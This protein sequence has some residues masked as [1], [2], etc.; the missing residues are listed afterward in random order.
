MS[1]HQAMYTLCSLLWSG[2]WSVT[3]LRWLCAGLQISAPSGPEGRP[4]SGRS[5][6]S[7]AT[8]AWAPRPAAWRKTAADL[9]RQTAAESEPPGSCTGAP[10]WRPDYST[11]YS[12]ATSHAGSHRNAAPL[13]PEIELPPNRCRERQVKGF[14]I[15]IY[16]LISSKLL[17]LVSKGMTWHQS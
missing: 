4:S 3:P 10:T 7:S 6:R 14:K 5:P 15:R 12:S 2:R 11:L 8:A 9:A 16:I 1:R 13:S 17:S